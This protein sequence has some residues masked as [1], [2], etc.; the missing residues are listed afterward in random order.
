MNLKDYL[1]SENRIFKNLITAISYE[2]RGLTSLKR[3]IENFTIDNIVL[4]NFGKKYLSKELRE[5]W[6]NQRGMLHQLFKKRGINFMEIDANPIYFNNFFYKLKGSIESESP[7]IINIS[8]LPKNYI[9]RFAK[10]FDNEKNIFFYHRYGKYREPTEDELKIGIEKIIPVEGFEG[11]RNIASEDLLILI[12]GYEGHRALSFLS[13]FEPYRILPLIS[14]PPQEN[15]KIY[16]LFY[17][18]VV[19]CNQNLLKRH[20]I[21]RK[22]KQFFTISSLDHILFFDQLNKI[23]NLYKEQDLDVSI[24]PIGTKAQVL[25]LYL[26]CRKNPDVQIIYSVPIKRFDI[27]GNKEMANPQAQEEDIIYRLPERWSI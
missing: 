12:L 1:K 21:I 6:D 5:T 22:D 11:I 19:R 17:N 14:T 7:N 4:I 16:K 3:I 10:E 27:T 20:R 15:K 2:K 23:I 13:I 18:N 8:T 24:S 26:Y 9:L 25:G